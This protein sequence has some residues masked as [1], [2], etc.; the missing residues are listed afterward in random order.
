MHK[1]ED[2]S[3]NPQ[4]SCKKLGQAAC[5][6]NSTTG[7]QRQK[8]PGISLASQPARQVIFTVSF[9]VR[10]RAYFVATRQ[11]DRGKDP[12]LHTGVCPLT[13]IHNIKKKKKHKMIKLSRSVVGFSFIVNNLCPFF[14]S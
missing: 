8:D 5:A 7:R 2:P 14:Q 10:E 11:S 13:H 9:Q 6:C 4:Q 12:V 3:L 1:H